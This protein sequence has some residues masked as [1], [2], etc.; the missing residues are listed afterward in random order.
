MKDGVDRAVSGEL[1]GSDLRSVSEAAK[2]GSFGGGGELTS[3]LGVNGGGA[4]IT[5]RRV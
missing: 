2:G 5:D 1:Q 4:G 3:R